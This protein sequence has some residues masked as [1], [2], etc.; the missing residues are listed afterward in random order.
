[1]IQAFNIQENITYRGNIVL[2]L[3]KL[4]RLRPDMDDFEFSSV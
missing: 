4:L 2:S 1:M 3:F